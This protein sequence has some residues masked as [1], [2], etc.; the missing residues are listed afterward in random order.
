[1][2]I[3]IKKLVLKSRINSKFNQSIYVTSVIPNDLL[4]GRPTVGC[5][6]QK[7]SKRPVKLSALV[8]LIRPHALT[9]YFE[10]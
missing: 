8:S 4:P 2:P 7:L 9:R 6:P 5:G 3:I 10:L 1:M